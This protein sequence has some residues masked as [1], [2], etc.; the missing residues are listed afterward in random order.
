MWRK[1]SNEVKQYWKAQAEKEK[2]E[3]L[4]KYPGYVYRPRRRNPRS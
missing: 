1:E 2:Q 4:R 3:H